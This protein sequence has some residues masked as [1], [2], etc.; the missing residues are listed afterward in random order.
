MLSHRSNLSAL[1]V[2]SWYMMDTTPLL[3]HS[4][5]YSNPVY[6]RDFADVGVLRRPEGY[7]AYA[8][9]G[10]VS[11]GMQN[12][13]CAFSPDLVHWQPRPDALPVKARW[14]PAQEYWAP[15]VVELTDNDYRMF[16]NAQVAGS[17]QGIGVACATRPE[18]PFRVVGEPLIYGES[19][20]HIDPKVF[21]NPL[22]QRWYLLW[23]SC[24]QPILIKELRPDLLGFLDPAS[25]AI[26]LL[27]PNPHNLTTALYEAAW[28][29]MR[30]DPE[31]HHHYFYLYTSGPDAFGD[32]SYSVHVA[33]STLGPTEGFMSLAEATGW[34]D[35]TIYRSNAT[36]VNPGASALTVDARGQ[37][38]LIS[39]AT[40]RADIPEHDQRRQS[41]DALWQILRYTRRVMILDPIDY[42]N[43]WPYV[44]GGTP[45]LSRQNGPV[46][47]VHRSRQ[48]FT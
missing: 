21:Q 44:P 26:D 48:A 5:P 23:G 9:Q 36:F 11:I 37:E 7:Y 28:M 33:R 18:G 46:Q 35:S 38:W 2:S 8:S 17:G 15:D 47:D 22:D 16:F 4:V 41:R 19:Y 27:K 34:E 6:F 31:H 25:A 40:L 1:A 32:E 12:I 14:A 20:R 24:Y 43:G 45:S 30:Y 42:Q 13:Q 3:Q 29:T 39:H 10:H